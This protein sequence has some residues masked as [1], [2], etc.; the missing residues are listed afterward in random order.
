MRFLFAL[1]LALPGCYLDHPGPVDG[2][3]PWC[4]TSGTVTPAP[5]RDHCFATA[6]ECYQHAERSGAL[7]INP[8]A[9]EP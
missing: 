5:D 3:R 4:W 8:W 1:A 9:C 6:A 2:S 7:T